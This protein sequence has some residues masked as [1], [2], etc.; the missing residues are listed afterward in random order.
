AEP[1]VRLFAGLAL[2][3]LGA[4]EA[5]QPLLAMLRDNAGSDP[6]LRHAGVM[7]LAGTKDVSALNG[8][9]NDPSPTVRMGV[10]LALR[11]LGNPEVARFLNDT[12]AS[13]VLEAA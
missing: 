4:R 12:D 11:R 1:R 10:L 13:I 2:G 6:Y 5:V 3:K 7:G 9:A 8:A